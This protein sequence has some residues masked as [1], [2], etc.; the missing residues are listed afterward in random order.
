M[1]DHNAHCVSQ[2][3]NYIFHNQ[4]SIKVTAEEHTSKLLRA[5]PSEATSREQTSPH[6]AWDLSSKKVKQ[7]TLFSS[8]NIHRNILL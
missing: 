4:K 2:K 7:Q 3:A 1:L 6:Q 8:F 5:L